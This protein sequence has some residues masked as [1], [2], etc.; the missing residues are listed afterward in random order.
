MDDAPQLYISLKPVPTDNELS[1]WERLIG[2]LLSDG[3]DPAAIRAA[4]AGTI[5]NL[6][7][8]DPHYHEGLMIK[9]GGHNA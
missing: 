1:R 8:I 4:N 9:L 3:S 6:R 5:E 2:K 7:R